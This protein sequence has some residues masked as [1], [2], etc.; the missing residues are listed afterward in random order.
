MSL[1]VS[2]FCIFQITIASLS[3]EVILHVEGTRRQYQTLI[4]DIGPGDTPDPVITI[5]FP[6]D[7]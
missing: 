4:L 6:A 5:A 1:R 2:D 7:F 3:F